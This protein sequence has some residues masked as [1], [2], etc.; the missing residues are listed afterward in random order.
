MK[1]V[2]YTT[3]G[4]IDWH[5]STERGEA[6]KENG[7]YDIKDEAAVIGAKVYE[8]MEKKLKNGDAKATPITMPA[9]E[10]V[11]EAV[12]NKAEIIAHTAQDGTWTDNKGREQPLY[13]TVIRG[14]EG[15]DG[16]EVVEEYVFGQFSWHTYFVVKN[17]DDANVRYL[18]LENFL[19]VC[20]GV[21]S[22]QRF[23]TEPFANLKEAEAYLKAM[24]LH[25]GYESVKELI[26][27]D[28]AEL[29][30]N[31]WY[32]NNMEIVSLL[33]EGKTADF[34]VFTTDHKAALL[35]G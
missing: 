6:L 1:T 10:E 31:L 34:R 17:I 16:Y 24:E 30:D 21:A 19:R 33:K 28:A 8:I 22:V 2:Q 4:S 3:Y 18:P 20:K 13:E 7:S 27:L 23:Y 9:L 32:K 29:K 14:F 35:A 5:D 11:I 12:R 15:E 26:I 25:S